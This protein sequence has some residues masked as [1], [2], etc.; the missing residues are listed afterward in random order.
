MDFGFT[1]VRDRV[2]SLHCLIGLFQRSTG[3]IKKDTPGV[4]QADRL[5][6]ALKQLEPDLIFEVANLPAERRLG[7][8][9]FCCGTRD[10]FCLGR[11]H[12]VTQMPQF[13][14][15]VQYVYWLC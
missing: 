4:H 10:V 9:K 12:K 5:C 14:S 2:R 7:Y 1:G 8:A 15:K 13:H 11:R 3:V 6:G